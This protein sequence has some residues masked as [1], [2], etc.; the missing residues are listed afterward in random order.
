MNAPRLLDGYCGAGGASRGYELGG[1]D[2]IIGVDIVDQPHYPYHF[3]KAN[4]LELSIDF[5]RTFDLI[6]CSPPCQAHTALKHA[7]NAKPHIDLIDSTRRMLIAAGVPYVI[8]NVV[9]A[10]LYSATTLCGSM[11]NCTTP[12]G[13]QL[14]RHRLFEC[15][16]DVTAPKCQHRRG[17]QVIGVYGGHARS[18]RRPAGT[19]HVPLSDFTAYDARYAMGVNWLVTNDELS[20]MIPPSFSQFIAQQW[21]AGRQRDS[22]PP[23]PAT[24]FVGPGNEPEM[25]Q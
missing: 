9:G 12:D 20:Q 6:H 21:L 22:Q 4:F 19:N 11:F 7:H 10:P 17:A 23:I 13:A 14:R 2:E 15:S 18:R 3:I 1:F 16:F 25:I 5:L 8:E 24:A